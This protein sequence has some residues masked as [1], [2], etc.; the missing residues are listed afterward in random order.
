MINNDQKG[1]PIASPI[2]RDLT[3]VTVLDPEG[4]DVPLRSLHGDGQVVLVWLRHDGCLFCKE[5]A[6]H[7]YSSKGE[8]EKVGG[9]L[10]FIGNGAIEYARHFR[11]SM[12][13]GG[14]VLTDPSAFS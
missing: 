7:L 13:P 3:D 11:D 12:I 6:I 5:Q 8:I 9:R 1:N 10:V 14:E 2:G 4:R